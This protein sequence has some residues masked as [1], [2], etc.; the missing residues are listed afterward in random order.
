MG[1]KNIG[2]TNCSHVHEVSF[3]L[4]YPIH[5]GWNTHTI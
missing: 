3:R 4:A 2:Q 5:V 1:S